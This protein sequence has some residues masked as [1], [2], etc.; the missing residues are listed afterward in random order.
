MQNFSDVSEILDSNSMM[1]HIKSGYIVDYDGN[2][3]RLEDVYVYPI[4]KYTFIDVWAWNYK[5]TGYL[6]RVH[7]DERLSPKNE[8][9][10]LVIPDPGE[11]I[12]KWS[13]PVKR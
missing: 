13:G 2:L 5:W 12:I 10:Y 6:L 11:Y 7:V 4:K 8:T 3:Y 9:E 1:Y